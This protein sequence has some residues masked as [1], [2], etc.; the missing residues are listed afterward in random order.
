MNKDNPYQRIAEYE[1][2]SLYS[3]ENEHDACGVGLV[4]SLNGDKSHEIV[5]TD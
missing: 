1:K 2:K 3:F 4:I 5:E